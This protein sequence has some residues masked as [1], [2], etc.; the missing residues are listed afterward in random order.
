MHDTDMTEASAAALRASGKGEIAILDYTGD[1]KLLWTVGNQVEMDAAKEM[2][3]KLR[4]KGYLAYKV[5]GTDGAKGE[6]IT[7]FDPEA[8][9][10]IMAPAMKGG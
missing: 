3:D 7:A 9:R 4:G 10:I 8:G 1:T 6:Q 2:F 5:V